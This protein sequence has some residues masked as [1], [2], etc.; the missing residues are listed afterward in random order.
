V[1]HAAVTRTTPAVVAAVAGLGAGSV[2]I[3]AEGAA[4]VEAPVASTYVVFNCSRKAEIKPVDFT[5]TCADNGFGVTKMHWSSGISHSASGYGSV[6]ENDD[7]PNHAE[8]RIYGPGANHPLGQRPDKR[9][10]ERVDLRLENGHLPRC[11]PRGLRLPGDQRQVHLPEGPDLP[12]LEIDELSSQ[13]GRQG[14][15]RSSARRPKRSQRTRPDRPRDR[16]WW[17]GAE[18]NHSVV[19]S[20]RCENAASGGAVGSSGR[21][22]ACSGGVRPGGRAWC[23]R[24]C[25]GWLP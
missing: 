24:A 19:L 20:R 23:A 17:R 5:S 15:D 2:R 4:P 10:S 16:C 3:L 9:Q 1:K 11:P 21:G 8:G 18:R 22:G 25:C 7:Y 13:Y 12:S 6:Y 14:G